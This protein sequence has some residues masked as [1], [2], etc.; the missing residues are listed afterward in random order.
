VDAI[1][2]ESG[3]IVD[4]QFAAVGVMKQTLLDGAP[5][6]VIILTAALIDGLVA[7]GHAM[8][9]TAA[10]LGRVATG[11][12]VPIGAPA[13]DVAD[14][15]ALASALRAAR[16]IY[17]P[18]PTRATAGIHFVDV[19]KRLGILD[20]VTPYLKPFPNGATAMAAMAKDRAPRSI[21]CTQVTEILYTE[22][23]TLTA[24][25][26]EGF[27]L[28][29]IYTAAVASRAQHPEDAKRF[30]ELLSGPSSAAIRRAGGF[31]F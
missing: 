5:C 20:E 31:S 6:D 14:G 17:F 10:A 28:E 29:T 21:G 1:A 30:V 27:G 23:V 24:L 11:I 16:A 19:L 2:P 22:G 13:P 18:D 25:L 15:P 4:G 9:G 12:A 7:E 26:P 8:P 3:T